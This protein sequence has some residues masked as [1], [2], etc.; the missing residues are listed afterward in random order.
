MSTDWPSYRQINY[1]L[2]PAKNVERKMMA[3]VLQG[4]ARVAPLSSYQ[5]VGFGS[6]Y[7]AD[8]RLFHR[9]FG[10][11]DMTS[12]EGNE[13]DERR[14]RYNRPYDCIDVRMGMSYR[15]LPSLEWSRRAIVWLDYDHEL[16]KYVLDDLDL[17][18]ARV[19]SGSVIAVTLDG[20][21]K[22]LKNPKSITEEER[23]GWPTSRRKQFE[24]LV[25]KELPELRQKDLQ[26][27]NLM[28]T[29]S[30]LLT[31]Q[32]AETFRVKNLGE[33]PASRWQFRQL[34]N[35]RYADKAQMMTVG[36]VVYQ[37][38][39]A[40]L[41]EECRLDASPFFRSSE[42]ALEIKIPNLTF[43]EMRAL[44]RYLPAGTDNDGFV[45]IPVPADEK[46]LYNE[47]YRFFPTFTEADL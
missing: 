34:F 5:Y 12:I 4:L 14:V 15:V 11:D 18:C 39:E 30:Q 40:E 9:M 10:M 28:R 41:V 13:D 27:R 8:Y 38:R 47:V 32:I 26:G 42:A 36:W 19:A 1:I 43:R 35:F 31:S 25:G 7:F 29:Y 23:E 46:R 22:R 44:D 3:D 2:R 45:E 17:V 24:R 37:E 6:I 33:E 20:E 16:A 21:A